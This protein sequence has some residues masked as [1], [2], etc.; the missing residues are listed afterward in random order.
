MKGWILVVIFF[1][2]MLVVGIWEHNFIV[3]SFEGLK[4]QTLSFEASILNEENINTE[5][6]KT[7]FNAI[8]DFWT[9]REKTLCLFIN[10]QHMEEVEDELSTIK[11]ALDYNDKQQV[12]TSLT[13]ILNYVEGYRDFAVISLESIF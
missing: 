6:I 8:N 5:A 9:K 2:L 13:L 7:E 4:T 11:I 1:V 3:D 10:H 12:L